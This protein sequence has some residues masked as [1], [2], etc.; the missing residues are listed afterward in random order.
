MKYG[1]G[2]CMIALRFYAVKGRG[3]IL[4]LEEFALIGVSRRAAFKGLDFSNELT[5]VFK[6]TINGYVAHVG[7]GI[8]IVQF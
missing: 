4:F 3:L 7:H 1:L 2:E 6:L 8:D 5:D